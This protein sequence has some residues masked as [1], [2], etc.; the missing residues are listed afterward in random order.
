[1][2]I[3]HMMKTDAGRPNVTAIYCTFAVDYAI[4]S[5]GEHRSTSYHHTSR[6]LQHILGIIIHG[7]ESL[8]QFSNNCNVLE[9]PTK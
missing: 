1:M 2:L 3:M 4:D 9:Q 7:Q 8:G 6:T 5:H